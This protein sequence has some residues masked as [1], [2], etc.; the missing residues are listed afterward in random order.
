MVEIPGELAK[1]VT[2]D[3]EMRGEVGSVA[4]LHQ[5]FSAL[6]DKYWDVID[7]Y[8]A[9]RGVKFHIA[10]TVEKPQETPK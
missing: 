8:P 1:Y 5:I 7:R 4:A 6:A 10:L 2:V 9:S 3:D